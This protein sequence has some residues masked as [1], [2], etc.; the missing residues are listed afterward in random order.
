MY[1]VAHRSRR[2][3]LVDRFVEWFRAGVERRLGWYDP[4]HERARNVRTE[5]IR[6][7]A[8]AAR[9][10]TEHVIEDYRAADRAQRG[11]D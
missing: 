6:Q 1:A 8:I 10:H 2:R 5:G 7:R 9:I 11:R 3:R 4:E